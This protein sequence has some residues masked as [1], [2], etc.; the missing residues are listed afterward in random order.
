[1]AS[2][3]TP[4]F[5][6]FLLDSA[7][8]DAKLD[9]FPIRAGIMEQPLGSQQG[10]DFI[11]DVTALAHE[12]NRFAPQGPAQAA[13]TTREVTLTWV[14]HGRTATEV[15]EHTE[16][17]TYEQMSIKIEDTVLFRAILQ[18]SILSVISVSSVAGVFSRLT[19]AGSGIEQSADLFDKPQAM[20]QGRGAM[21]QGQDANGFGQAKRCLRVGGRFGAGAQALA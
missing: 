20:V 8:N 3:A 1:M 14:A 16:N 15:T 18:G 5:Q 19:A 6:H 17:G 21:A 7:V 4:L 2:L 11:E 12:L 9:A 10:E 13:V